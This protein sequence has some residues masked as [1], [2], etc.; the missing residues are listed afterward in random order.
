MPSTV[1]RF[2]RYDAEKRELLVLFVTGRRYIYEDVP[3]DVAEAFGNA[4]SKGQFFNH[5][6]RDRYRYRELEQLA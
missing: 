5:E 6:I 1:I 3:P 2:F 4:F